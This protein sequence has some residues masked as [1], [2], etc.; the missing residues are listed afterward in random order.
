MAEFLLGF[1]VGSL[2]AHMTVLVAISGAIS[3]VATRLKH[4]E[5]ALS[6][7]ANCDDADFWKNGHAEDDDE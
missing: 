2:V 5:A 1:L 4:L 3:A 6:Q 7:Q